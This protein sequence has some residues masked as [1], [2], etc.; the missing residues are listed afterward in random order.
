[1]ADA[2]GLSPSGRVALA[3]DARPDGA[4]GE[5]RASVY[6]YP[7]DWLASADA[8][9]VSTVLGSCVSVCLWDR[10]T[11]SGGLNHFLLPYS[12]REEG[13]ACRFG[14]SAMEN[15]LEKVLALGCE[16]RNLTAR[17]FGGA[18]Q[19]DPAPDRASIGAQNV[20]VATRFLEEA[21]IPLVAREIG[22]T[23]GRRILFSIASGDVSVRTL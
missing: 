2:R 7:G 5:R 8:L 3:A 23:R 22:G 21:G 10:E 1:M 11:R 4:T 9:I 14:P 20:A 18:S 17:L 19:F 12:S 16:R 6:L 13:G 15:L